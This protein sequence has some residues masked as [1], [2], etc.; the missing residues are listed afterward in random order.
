MTDNFPLTKLNDRKDCMGEICLS[1]V[2][3]A[4]LKNRRL[5][6]AEICR[7]LGI[8]KS[9]FSGWLAGVKPSAKN[10]PMI[11]KLARF[12]DLPIEMLLFNAK[13]GEGGEQSTILFSSTFKDEKHRYKLTIEKILDR[14]SK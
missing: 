13:T 3:A 1:E 4:E 10:L 2:L 12:L 8:S 14:G 6:A 7:E 11:R 9:V 5:T